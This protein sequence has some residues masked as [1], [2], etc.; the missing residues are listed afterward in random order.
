MRSSKALASGITKGLLPICLAVLV[1]VGSSPADAR[2]VQSD[3]PPGQPLPTYV[4]DGS[5]DDALARFG[6][7]P[8]SGWGSS[9]RS[10]LASWVDQPLDGLS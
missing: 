5:I 6:N 10:D 3:W 2:V 9:L 8:S 4:Y 7:A 1:V